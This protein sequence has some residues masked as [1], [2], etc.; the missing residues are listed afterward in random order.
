MQSVVSNSRALQAY[1]LT[2]DAEDGPRRKSSMQTW[3][4]SEISYQ[5]IQGYTAEEVSSFD[6]NGL[7]NFFRY[8]RPLTAGEIAVYKGHRKIWQRIV[9]D[10][11]YV[12]LVLE[13]DAMII[14]NEHL[15]TFLTDVLLQLDYRSW[16]IIKLFNFTAKNVISTRHA[17]NSKLVLHRRPANGAVGYLINPQAAKRLL[18]RKR[19]FRPI[20]E[21]LS[22]PWE[23]GLRVWSASKN[24]LSEVSPELGGSLLEGERHLLD[25]ASRRQTIRF[26]AK[27]NILE[28]EKQLRSILYARKILA[29]ERSL[30][31][32]WS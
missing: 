13:D 30:V 21:D 31:D 22:H 27:R 28:L 5:F 25:V 2:V 4:A 24:L 12:G 15:K 17:G 16:D 23:L 32:G 20:D 9:E 3:A 18:C 14:D 10:G 7:T 6:Y 11:V 1:I 19:V 26:A 8:K 29:D